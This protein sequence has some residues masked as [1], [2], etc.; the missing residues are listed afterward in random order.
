MHAGAGHPFY[1]NR[2]RVDPAFRLELS[3]CV[4]KGIPHDK[5]LDW[6]PSSRAKTLAYLME[7][8]ERCQL[9]GTAPWEWKENQYAYDAEETFCKGCYVKEVSSEGEK[10]M[11]GTRIELVPVTRELRDRQAHTHQ[12]RMKMDMGSPD[13]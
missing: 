5:F 13:D 7:Q 2:I 4:E 1:R 8:A 12:M 11:P 9:C 6:D 3:Y 10:R